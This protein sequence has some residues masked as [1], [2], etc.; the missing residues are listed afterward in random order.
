MSACLTSDRYTSQC[1]KILFWRNVC[2]VSFFAQYVSLFQVTLVNHQKCLDKLN[3]NRFSCSTKMS[4]V[5][6]QR[7]GSVMVM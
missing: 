2:N 4:K 7:S 6:G 5:D 3:I 1:L